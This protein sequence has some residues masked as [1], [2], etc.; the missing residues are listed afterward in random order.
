MACDFSIPFTGDPAAVLAKAKN[1]VQSQGGNFN[2]D[3]DT[4]EFNVS[5]FGNKIVGNYTVNGQTL[6]INITDK[7][8]MVPCNA[9]ESFLKGQLK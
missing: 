1:A 6:N 3:A 2:G 8:F 5:V 4:G 7:P 9:I